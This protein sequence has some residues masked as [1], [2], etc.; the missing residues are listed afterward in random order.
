MVRSM[1]WDSA[2]LSPKLPTFLPRQRQTSPD[3]TTTTTDARPYLLGRPDMARRRSIVML[4]VQQQPE[5]SLE[6]G[7]AA[8]NRWT[9]LSVGSS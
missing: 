9:L 3:P 7:A 1:A 6:T 8:L 5:S 2:F 4:D